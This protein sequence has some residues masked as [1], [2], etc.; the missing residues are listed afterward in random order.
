MDTELTRR[1]AA[2]L[3]RDGEAGV[4]AVVDARCQTPDLNAEPPA[5]QAPVDPVRMVQ[6]TANLIDNAS[7]YTPTEGLIAV[8]LTGTGTEGCIRVAGDG[9]GICF[10]DAQTLL[11]ALLRAPEALACGS[12]GLG[13]GLTVVRKLVAAHHGSI[14]ARS[15]GPGLG[16][17]LLVRLPRLATETPPAEAPC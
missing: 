9:L 11:E 12:A 8:S 14:E 4:G 5:Q 2:A 10:A 3:L 17:E 6:V 1:M 7:R 16:S 13:N 15:A